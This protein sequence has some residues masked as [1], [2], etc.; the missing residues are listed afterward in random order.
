MVRVATPFRNR[1][2]RGQIENLRW[3]RNAL[4]R[5][6]TDVRYADMLREAC[7]QDP[8]FFI[9]AFCYTYDPRVEPFP[10]LP[11]ILYEFQEEAVLEILRSIG[12]NDLLIEKSRDMGASWIITACVLWLWLFRPM[13]SF[14]FVS[15]TEK[16]VDDA[17][18]PKS[19]FWKFDFLLD[20][21]P[22][23][24]RPQG[25]NRNEH[26]KS[27]HIEN[28]EN[29]SVVDG[30]STNSNVSRGDRRTAVLFDEFAAVEQ[31]HRALAASRDVTRSRIFNST[32]AGTNNAFYD[33]RQTGIK[34]LRLHW[35]AHP[36]KAA[37]LYTTDEDGNLKIIDEAGYPE[38]YLPVLDGRLRSPWYDA[39]RSRCASPQE[40]AQ[41]L[42]ID[43]LGSGFQYFNADKIQEAIRN[44]AAQ[45]I[46]VGEL[47]FD[48]ATGEP[49]KF[50]ERDGGHFEL[51]RF[52]DRDGRP[53][54]DHRYV[55]S[56]D[57]SAGTGASNSAISVY[58]ATTTEKVGQYVN[59]FIRPEALA[60]QAVAIATWFGKAL[61]IW[62]RNGPGR[63]F[64]SRV[65]DLHYGN[66]FC[67]RRTESFS[68]EKTDVPGWDSAK[69]TKAILLGSYRTAIENNRIVNRSREALLECLEYIYTPDGS[70][71]HS[72]STSKLDPSGA[73]ANHGDRVI[74]DALACLGMEERRQAPAHEKREIPI[75][76]LAWRNQMRE[77][78]KQ[79]SNWELDSAWRR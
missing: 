6:M 44:H 73:K 12:S 27:M 66:V 78:Q 55:V 71:E 31:G 43:Y 25:Y 63:Q 61:L 14:L 3:R 62:E 10:K 46:L 58:D 17:G 40:A 39:E 72:A 68:K 53:P 19:L 38:G 77:Q 52:L 4:A 13:Q 60:Y 54:L 41:E 59:P 74:A 11:F 64:G 7:R 69:E 51:W 1:V 22:P 9:N 32:P 36:A 37:G 67:K 50:H 15:R 42:D 28:P 70:I 56:V 35:S 45:P 20:N 23:W 79:T 2:P 48:V 5:A 18:N 21:L 33:I 34:R 65:M 47:D 75:G 29:G 26:R 24:L 30:E 49:T 16:Y 8:I 76:S 57:I